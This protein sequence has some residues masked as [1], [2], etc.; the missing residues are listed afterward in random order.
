MASQGFGVR[1]QT[2]DGSRRRRREYRGAK[3]AEWGRVWGEMSAPQPTVGFGGASWAPPAGSGAEPRLLSHFLH[4]LGHR[5][6]LVARK[7]DSLAQKIANS[8]LK[9]WWWQVTIATYKV[10]PMISYRDRTVCLTVNVGIIVVDDCRFVV[11]ASLLFNSLLATASLHPTLQVA[12]NIRQKWVSICYV[13]TA[14][15]QCRPTTAPLSCTCYEELTLLA[16]V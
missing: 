5:T 6:L 2:I 14:Y 9:K 15:A 8:T 13:W 4:I 16:M 10:A 7:Y 12:A 11:T 3:G 1:V